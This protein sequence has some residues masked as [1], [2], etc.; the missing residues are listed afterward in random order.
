MLRSK[1]GWELETFGRLY[2]LAAQ[3]VSH[4][5]PL[6]SSQKGAGTVSSACISFPVSASVHGRSRIDHDWSQVI[7]RFAV[8]RV[9]H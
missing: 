5:L 8:T 4:C 1:A 7:A 2:P 3:Q 6:R 9:D